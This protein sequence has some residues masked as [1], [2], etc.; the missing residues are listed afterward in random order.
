MATTTTTRAKPEL[1]RQTFVEMTDRELREHPR[2]LA[3]AF[4]ERLFW[5]RAGAAALPVLR[6]GQLWERYDDR[7][8]YRADC[9]VPH[10]NWLLL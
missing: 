1:L 4:A 7:D 2:H 10:P 8:G 6:D 3:R 5:E 9:Y